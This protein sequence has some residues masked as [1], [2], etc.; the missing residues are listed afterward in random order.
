MNIQAL[1]I[2]LI[3]ASLVAC[4]GGGSSTSPAQTSPVPALVPAAPTQYSPIA[5][6]I[7]DT[8]VY[9]NTIYYS[10]GSIS[11]T[12]ATEQVAAINATNGNFFQNTFDE[13]KVIN[14]IEVYDALR[15][16]LSTNSCTYS[17][18]VH[19]AVFPMFVGQTFNQNSIKNCQIGNSS[20]FQV[21][22]LKATG[23]VQSY[24]TI[25]VPA[26]TFNTLKVHNKVVVSNG[27]NT[28]LALSPYTSDQTCWVDVVSGADIKCVSTITFSPKIASPYVTSTSHVLNS[29][30]HAAD[31]AFNLT[32]SILNQ[33]IPYLYVTPG[34]R[35]LV[36]IP[37]NSW[38]VLNPSKPVTWT[39][40][41]GSNS[42]AL[43]GTGINT[44]IYNGL[45]LTFNTANSDGSIF[46]NTSAG[47]PLTV[48]LSFTL[49]A[50]LTSDPSKVVTVD[51]T[52]NP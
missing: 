12:A 21:V 49:Q 48:P 50:T 9:S 27:A 1:W 36:V 47:V 51:V 31:A 18:A 24:E 30:A 20:T 4:G 39:L 41:M 33:S 45:S 25:T 13:N 32:G 34:Y 15:G 19:D 7:G 14:R 35:S 29:V 5:V 10:N 3:A 16:E 46:I 52:V 40:T 22:D 38:F 43:A 17:P 8:Y 26:G 11:T 44:V 37:A 28:A 2:S 6:K 42:S 23:V